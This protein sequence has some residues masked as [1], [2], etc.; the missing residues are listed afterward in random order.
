MSLLTFTTKTTVV[1]RGRSSRRALLAAAPDLTPVSWVQ[2]AKT[3]G[4]RNERMS[5]VA[6]LTAGTSSGGCCASF[7][8]P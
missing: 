4:R 3:I 2:D 1:D 8:A 5:F 6:L 7:P